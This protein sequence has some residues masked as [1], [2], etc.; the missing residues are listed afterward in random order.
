MR[1]AIA[2][3]LHPPGNGESLDEI[4]GQ[5]EDLTPGPALKLGLGIGGCFPKLK[6]KRDVH[7]ATPHC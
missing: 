4:A 6:P 1:T 3:A 2:P 7:I 5:V